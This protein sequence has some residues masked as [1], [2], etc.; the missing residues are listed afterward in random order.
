LSIKYEENHLNNNLTAPPCVPLP[1]WVDQNNM[2]NRQIEVREFDQELFGLQQ[3]LL[4]NACVFCSTTLAQGYVQ[5]GLLSELPTT[6][7]V[8]N[9]CYY[10]ADKDQRT[11]RHNSMFIAWLSEL[12]STP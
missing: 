1:A 4:E 3:A 6:S 8:S 7:I 2:T 9:L 5:S 11:T 10:L 12:L